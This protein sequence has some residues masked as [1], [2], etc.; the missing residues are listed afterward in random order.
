MPTYTNSSQP[1]SP[2]MQLD[3]LK[4]GNRVRPPSPPCAGA[5]ACSEVRRASHVSCLAVC[6]P[7]RNGAEPTSKL[8]DVVQE[9]LEVVKEIE[10]ARL[11][12][13]A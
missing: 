5:R 10:P 11:R 2:F 1:S 3:W 12:Y 4:P 13:A 7:T 8:P 6:N 9:S